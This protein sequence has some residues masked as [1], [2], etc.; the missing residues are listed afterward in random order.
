MILTFSL[1]IIN[2]QEKIMAHYSGP[3]STG[4]NTGATKTKAEQ[5]LSIIIKWS[6]HWC[7][8]YW[9]AEEVFHV[10]EMFY[11]NQEA[12]NG[13]W[14]F[15]SAHFSMVYWVKGDIYKMNLWLSCW[16]TA[17]SKKRSNLTIW[18]ASLT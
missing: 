1:S 8:F 4:K 9:V 10:K 14:N 2:S 11:L 12:R 17:K 5:Q 18:H 16:K 3:L 6:P 7:A 15:I 13:L